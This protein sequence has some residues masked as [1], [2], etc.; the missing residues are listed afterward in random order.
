LQTGVDRLTIGVVQSEWKIISDYIAQELDRCDHALA[1]RLVKPGNGLL[2]YPIDNTKS[3]RDTG[4]Q[5]YKAKLKELCEGNTS[6]HMPVPF[7]LI[8]LQDKLTLLAKPASRR[9]TPVLERLR[10]ERGC[11][12]DGGLSYVYWSDVQLL[13]KEGLE[14]GDVY[15]ER[16]LQ[17]LVDFMDLQGVVMHNN[18][19]VLRDLVIIDQEW[20]IKQ[21][22]MIIRDPKL[23][24]KDVD[25]RMGKMA[26]EQLYQDGN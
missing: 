20:L 6:V 13:Y 15:S 26:S 4:V 21:L 12:R 1:E 24:N 10:R 16:D 2:F 9:D 7:A 18:A 23:H 25:K 8:K 14:Q 22:T 17:T 11:A 19:E 5:A 3:G